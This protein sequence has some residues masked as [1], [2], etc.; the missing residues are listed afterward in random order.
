MN[1][2]DYDFELNE[3]FDPYSDVVA[4]AGYEPGQNAEA[5]AFE[6]PCFELQKMLS[7]GTFYYSVVRIR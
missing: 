1:R 2:S 7:G 3:S 6:H 5:A 4:S